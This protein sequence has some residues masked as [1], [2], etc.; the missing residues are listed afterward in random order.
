MK[1]PFRLFVLILLVSTGFWACVDNY[2]VDI[3]TS[4]GYLLV[5]GIITDLDEPQFI[6]IAK[7]PEDAQYVSS[8]F[9]S[10]IIA[11]QKNATPVTKAHVKLLVN[12][13]Q[14]VQLT[15]TDPGTYQLPLSF[16]AKV[17]DTYQLN[18]YTIEGKNYESSIEKM[19]PVPQIKNV[20]EEF[21]AKGIKKFAA[22]EE[23]IATNDFYADFDDT[24]TTKNFYRWRWVQYEIQ[25]ICETCKQ[26]KYYIYETAAGETGDCFKDLTLNY[27]NIFDYTCGELCWDIFY[28]SAINIF[29]DIYTDGQQQKGKLVA[30]IPLNQSNAC[31]VSIQ[32]MSLTANAY[33]YLKLIQD[34]SV[35]VGTLADTPPAPIKSNV[36]NIANTNELVLGYFSVSSVAEVRY[37]LSRKNTTG[38]SYN[39]LFATI[40][41]RPP[42]LEEISSE[43]PD[44]PLAFCKKSRNRTPVFPEG[45]KW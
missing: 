14:V 5:D 26:G 44:I 25:K 6:T 16:K 19:L 34:Q 1:F 33:R 18:I 40:N 31:L 3:N 9:T 4:K 39:G 42:T 38:G 27:N 7:T 36:I 15:E 41:N 23:R 13:S 43:R 20:Y 2:N 8:E 21:N 28:S 37:M 17:G 32:Q 45:W 35:N 29:S 24:P 22:S 30:Q 12:G 11:K 10:T